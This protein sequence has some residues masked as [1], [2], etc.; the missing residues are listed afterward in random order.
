M[1]VLPVVDYILR[2]GWG[3]GDTRELITIFQSRSISLAH[4]NRLT[5]SEL[6][7]QLLR[8]KQKHLQLSI[9]PREEFIQSI[10]EVS[11]LI[12]KVFALPWSGNLFL[13]LICDLQLLSELKSEAVPIE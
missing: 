11:T 6:S 10:Q 12:S 5:T 8:T 2:L 3:R 9:P 1:E 7:T 13:S 4:A